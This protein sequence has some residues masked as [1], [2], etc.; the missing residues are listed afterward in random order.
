MARFV[1]IPAIPEDDLSEGQVVLFNAFKENL[2][3]LAGIR[4]ANASSIR[5]IRKEEVRV[6]G[7]PPQASQNVG[8]SQLTVRGQ[9]F[10]I[11]DA[12][13]PSLEDYTKLINDVLQVKNDIAA[14]ATE[15][16]ALRA[17]L[18]AL[19]EQLRS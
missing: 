6:T 2:E 15:T 13:V 11:E 16:N 3:L 19:I 10:K 8:T 17:T 14:L 4:G 18:E 9:G 12:T 5:A 1:G 7:V